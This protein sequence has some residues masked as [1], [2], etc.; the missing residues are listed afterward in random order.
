MVFSID[1]PHSTPW[2]HDLNKL[3]SLTATMSGSLIL[4]K[5]ELF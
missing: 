5:S 3:E 1:W 4:C 2:D